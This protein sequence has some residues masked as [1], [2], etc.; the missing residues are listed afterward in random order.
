MTISNHLDLTTSAPSIS[1][2]AMLVELSISS[3]TG[4][5]KDKQASKKVTD[6]NGADAAVASVNKTLLAD[7]EHLT[8]IKTYIGE[9]RN[10]VHYKYTM[11]WSDTGIRLLPTSMFFEYQ[12][13]ISRYEGLI[14]SCVDDLI[15]DF[16]HEK[17]KAANK[18][19][20]LFN[21]EDYPTAESLRDKFN[22]KVNYMPLPD[23]GDFRLDINNDAVASLRSQYE[24]A[25]TQK[26]EQAMND[27]WQRVYTAL[28]N[29]SSRL[30]YDDDGKKLVFR[31]S[32]VENAVDM[33]DLLRKCNVTG[34]NQM[35]A[36][37]DKLE[38]VL[39]G[40]SAEALR[41]DT[42]LRDVVKRDIDEL[43]KTLP[44]LNF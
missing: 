12:Q 17:A 39:R 26:I 11:P 25:Y 28:S 6:D 16:E 40:N 33:V 15:D 43:I 44:S 9:V 24:N 2:A 38:T 20:A 35:F 4:R 23:A 30:G 8:K 1:S 37:A 41:E 29:M 14:M 27:I 34:S 10:H 3:W 21:P 32:L 5:K 13:E 22:F 42:G 18:L 36:M 31:D 7:C 19:G